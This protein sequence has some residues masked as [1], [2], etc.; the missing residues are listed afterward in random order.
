MPT[1]S[2][3]ALFVVAALAFL[4]VPGPSV[5]YI[6]TRSI[7]HGRTAGVLSA[8]GVAT[9]S[10]V[11]TAAAALG[12]S[13]ILL[14]SAVAFTTVK[15]AGAAYLVWIGLRRLL[16]P[17]EAA[18]DPAPPS[19]SLRRAFTHGIVVNILNPKTALFFLAFLPQFADPA[20]GPI[21]VQVAVLGVLLAL[22]GVLSDG[23]YALVAG[24]ASDWLRRHPRATRSGDR[25][26]GGVYVAL[27]LTAALARRPA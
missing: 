19:T 11:H 6:V 5:L 15:F 17:R 4:A 9:G 3:F 22:L 20:R 10:L 2:T 26:A 8:V 24:S 21:A 7:H 23:T 14:T 16:A 12:L 27:G 18:T 25:A 13:A 1:L